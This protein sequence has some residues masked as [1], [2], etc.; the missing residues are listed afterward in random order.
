MGTVPGVQKPLTEYWLAD[1]FV[2]NNFESYFLGVTVS[3]VF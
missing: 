2:A 3:P 1:N